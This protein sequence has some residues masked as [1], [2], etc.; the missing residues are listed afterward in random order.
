ML[1]SSRN[2]K[3]LNDVTAAQFSVFFLLLAA[4]KKTLKT[5]QLW[6]HEGPSYFVTTLACLAKKG[7]YYIIPTYVQQ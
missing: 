2:K 1:K 6:R 4:E 3:D 5:G 7:M